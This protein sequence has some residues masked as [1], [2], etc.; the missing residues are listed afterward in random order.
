ME[1]KGVR[2]VHH[3]HAWTLTSGKAVFSAHLATDEAS[4]SSLLLKEAH[5]LLRERFGFYF[6]TI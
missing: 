2:D 5:S 3:L 4:K 6:S 1:L